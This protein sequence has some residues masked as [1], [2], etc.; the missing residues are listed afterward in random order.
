MYGSV[1]AGSVTEYIYDTFFQVYGDYAERSRLCGILRFIVCIA[2]P[3]AKRTGVGN[4][5]GNLIIPDNAF[6]FIAYIHAFYR[7]RMVVPVDIR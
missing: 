4:T 6:G 1:K 2:L 5:D 7:E 3:I